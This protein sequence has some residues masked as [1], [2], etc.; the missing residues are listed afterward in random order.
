MSFDAGKA[1]LCDKPFGANVGEAARMAQLARETGLFNALNFEFRFLPIR[2]TVKRLVDEGRLGRVQRVAWMNESSLSLDPLRPFGWVFERSLGGGWLRAW[3]SH[4]IDTSLWLVGALQV[5]DARLF[6]ALGER[7][8]PAGDMRAVTADDGFSIALQSE[9]GVDIRI[10]SS[11]ASPATLP[12]Q[13]LVVGTDAV[14]LLLDD[15]TLE[16][17]R[18]DRAT[19]LIERDASASPPAPRALRLMLTELS[20][21]LDHD[22]PFEPSFEAGTA[23]ATTI[24]AL[25]RCADERPAS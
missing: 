6:R 16:L 19:E 13:L 25:V 5:R 18:Y 20:D 2:R 23:C 9:T 3:G 17:R 4:A 8:G 22:R 12:E 14:L 11:F 15:A 24:D 7:P 21:A 1:V 10:T